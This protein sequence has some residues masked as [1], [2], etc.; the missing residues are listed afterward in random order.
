MICIFLKRVRVFFLSSHE[1]GPEPFLSYL[2]K[3]IL[4]A[5]LSTSATANMV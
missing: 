3:R 2:K 4:E 1:I 5:F